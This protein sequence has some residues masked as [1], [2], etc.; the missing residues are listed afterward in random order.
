MHFICVSPKYKPQIALYFSSSTPDPTSWV[1]FLTSQRPNF[2]VCKTGMVMVPIYRMLGARQVLK[3][4]K[5][6]LD[7]C[8]TNE[9]TWLGVRILFVNDRKINA[10]GFQG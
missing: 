3:K 10:R 7:Q 9:W 5:Q 6:K 1:S 2:F 8:R 4:H